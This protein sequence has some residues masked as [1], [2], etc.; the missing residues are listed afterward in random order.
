MTFHIINKQLLISVPNK[1]QGKF[2]FK[3]RSHKKQFGNS[4]ASGTKKF[5]EKIY[6]EWQIGYDVY[7][8]DIEN[9]KKATSLGH[10]IFKFQGANG[11][12]KYPYELS[13]FL[14][15]LI[16]ENILKA[17][18]L[19]SLKSEIEGYNEFLSRTPKVQPQDKVVFNKLI[20]DS[21]IT[22]LAGYYFE[23]ED[24]TYIEIIVQKQQYASG[25]Q[26]MIYF[27]I[28]IVCFSNG[29]EALG[30]TSKEKP[31]HFKYCINTGNFEN[32]LN[33]FKT[34]AMASKGH[35][36]D[37]IEILKALKRGLKL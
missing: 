10:S 30:W 26:P 8:R 36:H 9:R 28:P 13:E 3:K 7:M 25:F 29:K 14:Y 35:Q 1:N 2:R 33:L 4:F 34:L 12:E 5:D 6:L 20:F 23:N 16:K 19:D 21:T 22:E 17:G 32:I 27:C 37:I 11:K 24:K 18:V 15:L 31:I